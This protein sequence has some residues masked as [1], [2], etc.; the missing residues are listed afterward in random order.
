[1]QIP[2]HCYWNVQST[3]RDKHRQCNKFTIHEFCWF[4]QIWNV[5]CTYR[6]TDNVINLSFMS[7]AEHAN[8]N[9]LL[10][11][12]AKHLQM[13]RQWMLVWNCPIQYC[14][15]HT[16]DHETRE[17]DHSGAVTMIIKM[18]KSTHYFSIPEHDVKH[19]ALGKGIN[20]SYV[21]LQ[22]QTQTILG[23]AL[24]TIPSAF[25]AQYNTSGLIDERWA[26]YDKCRLNA[27]N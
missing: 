2:A 1:M 11:K 21:Q 20:S 13:H 27:L 16:S 19:A 24:V 18:E 4:G 14:W 8:S 26:N 7:F 17:C 6:D 3:Y 5:R 10:L 12:C 9:T 23:P 22:R 15:K 25:F